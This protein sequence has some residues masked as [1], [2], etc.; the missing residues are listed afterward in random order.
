MFGHGQIE[1]FTEK[2]GMEYRR[3]YID[4]Q[5][6]AWLVERHEREIFPLLH[7]RYIFAE[8]SNFLL[9]DFFTPEGFV[10]EDVFAY[11]N[12]C[13]DERGLVVYHNKFAD[14]RGWIRS[15]VGFAVKGPGGEKTIQQRALAD[16]LAL[17]DDASYYTIFR[18]SLTGLEYLRN[19][20]ELCDH[21][22]VCGVACLHMPRV[23]RFPRSAGQRLAPLPT[24]DRLPEW[25]RSTE[26]RGGHARTVPAAGASA[27]QRVGQCRHVPLPVR[28]SRDDAGY[29]TR[30][31]AVGL[32]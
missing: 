6:D 1:G 21:G 17:H 7:K 32:K 12:R 13:G 24:P 30:G 28:R 27:V 9:Y 14:A 10:D 29:R 19:S 4:E 22:F 20:K 5:P 11:S 15:S 8:A 26:H 18:D 16:G 23:S 25:T 2:Y 31:R 3:A